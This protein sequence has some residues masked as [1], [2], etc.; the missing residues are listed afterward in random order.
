MR[1]GR[2]A[3]PV[4]VR[5]TDLD[6]ADVGRRDRRDHRAPAGRA[7]GGR[8]SPTRRSTTRR[9]LA[10]LQRS[11]TS[12]FSAGETPV[13]GLP[14]PQ[15]DQ[16]RRAGHPAAQRVPRRHQ[17]RAHSSRVHRA[18][19]GRDPRAGRADALQQP[20]PRVRHAAR[21][22]LRDHLLGPRH[23]ATWSPGS[24]SVRTTRPRPST[25]SFRRHPV[26]GRTSLYLSTPERCA[27]DQRAGR[28]RDARD[29]SSTCY[30]HS[31]ARGEHLPARV[32]ARRRGDLGQR[33]R[34]APGRPRRRGRR[35]GDAPRHGRRPVPAS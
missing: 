29:R 27:V 32:V 11:A 20:V 17:L 35:P 19:G 2:A 26:S 24:T 1:H 6:V 7:R 25:R 23:R 12:T 18:A 3:G 8:C 30:A 10:F 21:R 31:T 4:G 5:I 34:A 28:R 13:D 33:L 14:R 15:R 22:R 9:S 16:Q